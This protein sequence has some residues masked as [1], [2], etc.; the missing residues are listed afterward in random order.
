[1]KRIINIIFIILWMTTVF[2]F[3]NQESTESSGVSKKITNNIVKTFHIVD[4]Y[5][6]EDKQNIIDNI[7]HIIRKL[8]HYSLYTLGGFL[9]YLEINEYKIPLLRKIIYTQ[10]FGTSYACTDELHQIL[11]PGRSGEIKDIFIDSCGIFTGVVVAILCIFLLKKI[12][13]KYLRKIKKEVE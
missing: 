2:I 10:I 4:K 5:N 11:I 12:K 8:A 3:S 7:E 13:E 6:E 1:M 9:I